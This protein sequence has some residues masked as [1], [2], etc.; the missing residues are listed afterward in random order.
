MD[1]PTPFFSF[2]FF[3]FLF[4]RLFFTA[5]FVSC[6]NPTLMTLNNGPFTAPLATYWPHLATQHDVA[7]GGVGDILATPSHTAHV[8][9]GG[10]A[11]SDS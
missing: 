9:N 1:R 4:P 3:F 2:F 8:A 7:N 10:V 5:V 6:N 11:F